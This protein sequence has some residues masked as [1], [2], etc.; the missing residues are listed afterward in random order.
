[1]GDMLCRLKKSS[2]TAIFQITNEIIALLKQKAIYMMGKYILWNRMIPCLL[3][4][5]K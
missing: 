4:Y 5:H 2:P 3:F 1:M